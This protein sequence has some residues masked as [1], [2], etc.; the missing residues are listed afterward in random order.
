LVLLDEPTA[1]LDPVTAGGIRQ[2]V[3]RLM[4]DRTIVL[5]T[6]HRAWRAGAD[7]LVEMRDG[8]PAVAEEV[9]A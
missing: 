6:H 5:V 3:E 8:R 1:H 2:A 4:T 9:A 7:V